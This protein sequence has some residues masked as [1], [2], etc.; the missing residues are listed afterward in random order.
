VSLKGQTVRINTTNVK[1]INPAAQARNW[2][3]FATN[4]PV[5]DLCAGPDALLRD[6][7]RMMQEGYVGKVKFTNA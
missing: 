3:K 5:V 6:R 4:G 7:L 1:A 2:S